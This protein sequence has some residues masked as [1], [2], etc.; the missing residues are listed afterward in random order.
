MSLYSRCP[1]ALNESVEVKK[2]GGWGGGNGDVTVARNPCKSP[3]LK[4][5]LLEETPNALRLWNQLL[6]DAT[7][8]WNT[9]SNMLKRSWNERYEPA[10]EH[11]T[12][13]Q[14]KCPLSSWRLK[15][16]WS[17]KWLPLIWKA[18]QRKEK[19]RFH[20]WNIF[21]RLRDIHIF[22][23]CKSAWFLLWCIYQLD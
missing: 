9:N 14:E 21:F 15:C 4:N 3:A 6:K 11:V 17:K 16:L 13:D 8:T 5:K 2:E 1:S 10:L 18:F 23:L 22:V 19:W 20:F 7:A 12:A